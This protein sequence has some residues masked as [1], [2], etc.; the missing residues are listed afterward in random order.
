MTI[1][2]AFKIL[3]VFLQ[4]SKLLRLAQKAYSLLS[5]KIRQGSYTLTKNKI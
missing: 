5:L 1:F 3:V 2:A 4:L